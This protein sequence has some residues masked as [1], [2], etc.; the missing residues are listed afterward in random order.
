MRILLSVL[1]LLVVSNVAVAY[2]GMKSNGKWGATSTTV[3]SVGIAKSKPIV[4]KVPKPKA[5]KPVKAPKP[6]KI[7]FKTPIVPA[8]T[9]GPVKH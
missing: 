2:P 5:V 3:K 8:T 7:K 6:I 9:A 1:V 4:T